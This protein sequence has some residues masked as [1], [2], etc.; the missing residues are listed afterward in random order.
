[1]NDSLGHKEGDQL[2][3]HTAQVLQENV[4][5][6]DIVAR[7]GGDEFVILSIENDKAGAE[8]LLDRLIEAFAEAKLKLHLVWR[9]V[10]QRL[11]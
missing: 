7:I 1:M 3:Q 11:A 9:C 2:I 4:R 6:N 5:S 10:I 8:R